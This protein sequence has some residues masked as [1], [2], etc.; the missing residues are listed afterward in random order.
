MV[1]GNLITGD[2]GRR[3]AARTEH[4][5]VRVGV[6]QAF[7]LT[8]RIGAIASFCRRILSASTD[9]LGLWPLKWRAPE[10]VRVSAGVPA[11]CAGRLVL[12]LLFVTCKPKSYPN[13]I[14]QIQPAGPDAVVLEQWLDCCSVCTRN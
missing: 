1:F 13:I 10:V 8:G 9:W 14:D 2:R 5:H 4:V 6:V 11:Q 3:E 12:G 7:G